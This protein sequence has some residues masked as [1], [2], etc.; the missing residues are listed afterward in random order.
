LDYSVWLQYACGWR[1]LCAIWRTRCLGCD[2]HSTRRN[3]SARIPCYLPRCCVPNRKRTFCYAM[4][5]VN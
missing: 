5:L 1:F 2:P 3:E 4:W